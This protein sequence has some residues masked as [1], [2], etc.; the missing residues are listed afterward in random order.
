MRPSGYARYWAAANDE[1]HATQGGTGIMS[2]DEWWQTPHCPECGRVDLD[3][4]VGEAGAER[5]EC[6]GVD[7]CGHSWPVGA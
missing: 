1:F 6:A 5:W 4:G 3:R 2:F 7:G